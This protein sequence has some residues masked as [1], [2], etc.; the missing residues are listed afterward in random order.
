M[1]EALVAKIMEYVDIGIPKEE[2]IALLN[3]YF[4]YTE[5]NKGDFLYQEGDFVGYSTFVESGLLRTYLVNEQ[6]IEFTIQFAMKGWWIGD[7]ASVITGEPSRFNV[8]ALENTKVLTIPKDLFD[9][10]L[11]EAPFYLNYHH[12]LLERSVIATQNRLIESYSVNAKEKYLSLLKSF[13]DIFQRVPQYMIASY[14][15]MTPETL[16][17]IRGQIASR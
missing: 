5:I 9:K 6:G 12:K 10:L 7:L 3:N 8:Q 14:L 1:T 4:S 17:R 16:S 11:K 2:A 13:P 15:G